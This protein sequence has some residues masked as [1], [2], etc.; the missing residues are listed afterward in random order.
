MVY[1]HGDFYLYQVDEVKTVVPTAIEVTYP[2]TEPRL[3]LLTCTIWDPVRG[4]FAKRLV[5][6]A[7]LV[8]PPDMLKAPVS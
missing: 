7:K 5:V 1:D 3:T 8:M 4:V 2:T 6:T